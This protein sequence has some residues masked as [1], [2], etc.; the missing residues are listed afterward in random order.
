MRK[1]PIIVK[2]GAQLAGVAREVLKM[3]PGIVALEG[4]MGAG[5]T[6]FTKALAKI[7]GIKDEIVS[8]TFVLH[9]PYNGL[10]HLDCWRME[11]GGELEQIGFE[12]ILDSK[13]ITV[14]EWAERVKEVILKYQNQVKIVWV[15]ME[16]GDDENERKITIDSIFN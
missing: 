3:K 11:S 5:K 7:L 14:V 9:R 16:Y 6:T 13:S 15:K 12:K 2:N 10:N 4:P 1:G 8:P